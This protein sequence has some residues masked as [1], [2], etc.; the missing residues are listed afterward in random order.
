[1]R[2]L[3]VR[4]AIGLA[5]AAGGLLSAHG[6][7]ADAMAQAALA[8]QA[9]QVSTLLAQGVDPD[10]RYAHGRTA[11]MIAARAGHYETVRRLLIGGATKSLKDSDGKTALDLAAEFR[12]ADLVALM[13]EG[14]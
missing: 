9:D 12:H 6:A 14:S 1:L 11:L 2:K 13:Q 8:G 3:I 7:G 4:T 10:L 5:C